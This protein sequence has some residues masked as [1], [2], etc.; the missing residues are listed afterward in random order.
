MGHNHNGGC[1]AAR[2]I[3]TTPPT[4]AVP[5]NT[6]VFAGSS[7]G[8]LGYETKNL[9]V[10]AGGDE[11]SGDVPG[12]E[13]VTTVRLPRQPQPGWEFTIGAN[14]VN[15]LVLAGRRSIGPGSGPNYV[16][17]HGFHVTFLFAPDEQEGCCGTCRGGCSCG[18]SGRWLVEAGATGAGT[19][20]EGFVETAADLT[21][22]DITED[23][24]EAGAVYGVAE[25]GAL[26]VLDLSGG[27]PVV[28]GTTVIATST[29]A[30]AWV[31]FAS[32]ATTYLAL[33]GQGIL[34]APPVV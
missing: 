16:V 1:R 29:G 4:N 28:N 9:L 21:A 11:V 12:Q 18:P 14:G 2:T 31:Q 34:P 8:E 20:I 15:V 25:F 13:L 30:G 26:Y 3:S 7:Y 10:V 17:P 22:V 19:G 5:R 33:L 27:A 32:G 23:G 24:L 6:K